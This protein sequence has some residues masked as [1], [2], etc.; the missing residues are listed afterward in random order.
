MRSSNLVYILG[1]IEVA[2][3]RLLV[4]V[5][6]IVTTIILEPDGNHVL[7]DRTAIILNKKAMEVLITN[8]TLTTIFDRR[9]VRKYLPEMIGDDLLEKVLDAGRMAPSAMNRQPWKFYIATHADTIASFS[10]AIAKVAAKEILKTAVRHPVDT[11]KTLIH[12]TTG[13]VHLPDEHSIFHG[14]PVVI[15][16]TAPKANEW[17]RLDVGMCAQNIM[18]AAQS[19]GLS[20]C[21]V[22]FAKYIEKTAVFHKLEVPSL[23]EVLLAVVLGHG[24]EHPVPHPRVKDNAIFID[25]MECC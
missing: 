25:R 16:I 2:A 12:F 4:C 11:F 14:A 5:N 8:E 3:Y 10:K 18:L 23:E 7:A 21:P 22:G 1:E 20:S 13:P 15:F 19:L 17:A 9:A 6:C 24:A